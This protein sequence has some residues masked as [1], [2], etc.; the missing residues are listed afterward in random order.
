MATDN[1]RDSTMLFPD[2]QENFDHSQWQPAADSAVHPST[3]PEP[4]LPAMPAVGENNSPTTDPAHD[5]DTEHDYAD[6]DFGDIAP[7]TVP[8]PYWV[9]AHVP[10]DRLVMDQPQRRF[11]RRRTAAAPTPP[12][13]DATSQLPASPV[14]PRR[15][16]SPTW[17]V[18]AGVAAAALI[19]AVVVVNGQDDAPDPTN[20]TVVAA[21]T[22]APRAST[23]APTSAAPAPFCTAASTPDATTTDAAGGRGNAVDVIAAFEHAYYVERSG[24]AVAS[25]MVSPAPPE[26]IQA[27]ID[28]TPAGTEHCV[29]IAATDNP[30]VHA[31]ALA[32]RTPSGSESAIASRIT[33]VRTGANY[34]ISNVEEVR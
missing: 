7:E 11:R 16:I 17:I 6:A 19:G 5:L 29:T 2:P 4:P 27:V 26:R 30:D 33:T 28:R 1:H 15:R 10:A 9:A 23:T 8:V 14:R 25:L 34:A 20:S 22:A 13:D 32:L 12:V 21:P 3:T 18:A 24:A 31:V